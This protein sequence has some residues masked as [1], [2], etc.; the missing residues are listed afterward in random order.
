TEP[1]EPAENTN[2]PYTSQIDQAFSRAWNDVYAE[3]NG[4]STSTDSEKAGESGAGET[5]STPA[6]EQAG[7]QPAQ[8]ETSPAGESGDAAPTVPDAGTVSGGQGEDE[9]GAPADA[10]AAAGAISDPADTRP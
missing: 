8:T 9:S 2:T 4:A 3:E 5:S 7:Q 10:Q 1:V 6:V